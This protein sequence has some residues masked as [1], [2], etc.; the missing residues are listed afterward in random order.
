M[1]IGSGRVAI[2]FVFYRSGT[3]LSIELTRFRLQSV[4][5]ENLPA[6]RGHDPLDLSIDLGPSARVG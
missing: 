2:F 4:Q 5:R 3:L 6:K 1:F